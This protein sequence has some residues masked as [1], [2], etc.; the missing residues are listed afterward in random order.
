[1]NRFS[2]RY[3]Y[4]S[5]RQVMIRECLP[6]DVENCI[7]SCFDKLKKYFYDADENEA[8]EDMQIYIWEHYL[9]KRRTDFYYER[10]KNIVVAYIRCAN[11]K[12]YEKI[13]IL[14]YSIGML[15]AASNI[16]YRFKSIY[17]NFVKD[18]NSF[19]KEVNFAY[20]VIDAKIVEITSEEEIVAIEQALQDSN[21]NVTLHLKSALQLYSQ[22]P[23]GDY[24]NSIKE[25]ISAVEAYC[26]EKTNENT[27][28]K[29]LKKLEAAGIVIP[30]MLNETFQKLY[31]YTNQPDN[32]IRHALMDEDGIYVPGNEEAC[33]MLVSCCSFINYLKKKNR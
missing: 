9:H 10:D 30:K 21:D 11:A 8:Y 32:G 22:K 24:R 19:F 7:C 31:A 17:L 28:G 18:I 2:D 16:Q 15:F 1:M 26:R 3:G 12:W 27:L 4:T 13:N 5:P 33:F 6:N 23:D 14:E 29:A 25:S 20:R